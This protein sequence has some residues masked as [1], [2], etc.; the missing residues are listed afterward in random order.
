MINEFILILV[1]VLG[2]VLTYILSIKYKKGPV[3]ASALLSLIVGLVCYFIPGE[4]AKVIPV[5]FIGAS[6]AGMASEEVIPNK[7]MM[8]FSGV[9]FGFIFINTSKFF[10]GFG[11]GLGTTACLSVVITLGVM[12]F[13]KK[14]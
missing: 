3:L 7:E 6:F 8:M 2:A 13:V 12:E 14:L 10:T 11:G 4:L 5:A 1:S 9:V